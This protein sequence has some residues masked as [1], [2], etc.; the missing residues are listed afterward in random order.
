MTRARRVLVVDDEPHVR[1][2]I[3]LILE[4]EGFSVD[5]ATD[6]C[7]ALTKARALAPDVV[8]LDLIMPILDG[9]GFLRECRVDPACGHVPILVM[10]A[11]DEPT[12]VNTLGAQ[13]VLMKPFD[14]DRLI[15]ELES[16]L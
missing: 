16:V 9:A 2:F 15:R 4:D 3:M 7:E 1:G 12:E 8:L 10:S 6:G 5:T 13:R 11:G 14:L